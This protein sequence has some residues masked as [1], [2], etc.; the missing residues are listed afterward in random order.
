LI[1]YG[2]VINIQDHYIQVQLDE[3]I[4]GHEDIV[5]KIKQNNAETLNR[6]NV[7]PFVPKRN[8]KEVSR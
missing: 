4:V 7:K 6:L 3:I 1:G 8:D 5:Q 2:E